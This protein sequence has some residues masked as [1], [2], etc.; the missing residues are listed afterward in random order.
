MPY[1]PVA[2]QRA[3]GTIGRPTSPTK[4]GTQQQNSKRGEQASPVKWISSVQA[5]SMSTSTSAKSTHASEGQ[6][7]S[8]QVLQEDVVSMFPQENL[9][10]CFGY[11]SGV[12]SQT[13]Q[14]ATRQHEGLLDL[15]FVVDDTRAFHEANLQI[16]P[17]HYT[18]WL[19]LG[20]PSLATN[21]QRHF[22]LPD[23]RVMF[24]VVD[25]P[26][27]MK[28]GVV[29]QE[30]LMEDLTQWNTLYLSGRLHK[31]TLPL[32]DPPPDWFADAQNRNLQAASAAALLLM[33]SLQEDELTFAQFCQAVASLSYTGDFRMQFGGED[34][35]KLTKLV[36]A[37]GQLQRFCRM[38]RP[39]LEQMEANGD[40]LLTDSG[41]DDRTSFGI[42]WDPTNSESSTRFQ[43]TLPASIQACLSPAFDAQQ[44]AT[45]LSSALSATVA[46]AARR[47]SFKGVGTLGFRRSLKYASAKLSKG[48]FATRKG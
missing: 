43:T 32:I 25:D 30:D 3:K 11:G 45:A 9:V 6:L 29:D 16:F 36:T 42:Q 1:K 48:L 7:T 41:W 23:A 27:P 31:P 17:Q 2:K 18:T 40:L 34:P 22:P 20:G 39:I 44:V 38:Y 5:R 10:Y 37:P 47:Q 8:Q 14:D 28:Y 26:V 46:P 24:H 13:L 15:I 4:R 19:R 12:F 33:T 21:V 35:Q